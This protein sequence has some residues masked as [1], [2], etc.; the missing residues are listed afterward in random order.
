MSPL[1]SIIVPVYN[2]ENYLRACLDSLINQSLQDVEF[3]CIDDGSSDESPNILDEY[4]A[5]DDRFVVIH[6]E[7]GGVSAARNLGLERA[8][9]RYV[10][11]VDSDD[12][13]SLCACERLVSIAEKENAQIVV[14][15]GKTF[16]VTPW[17]DAS[18]A[19]RNIVY[20]DDS[21]QALLEEQ[22]SNPL[23]CNKL[24]ERSLIEEGHCRFDE[25]LIIGE[26][27]AFQF[28]VFPLAKNIAFT[29]ERF[30]FY[31]MRK[32]SALSSR[33]K[34]HRKIA[35]MHFDVAERILR[36]W[37]SKG[38]IELVPN[39]I[40]AWV[41]LFLFREASQI[42]YNDRLSF[43]VSFS[44]LM[45][46]VFP[47]YKS[48]SVDMDDAT[49]NRISFMLCEDRLADAPLISLVVDGGGASDFSESLYRSIELQTMQ[50]YEILLVCPEDGI[51]AERAALLVEHDS[52][53]SLLSNR[54][55]PQEILGRA[56]GTY[57][58]RIHAGE[59]IEVTTFEQ[60]RDL[61][62]SD[63]GDG[64]PDVVSFSDSSKLMGTHDV[65]Y[66]VEPGEEDVRG[67]QRCV[68]PVDFE[69]SPFGAMSF[70]GCNKL[71]R[72]DHFLACVST[73]CKTTGWAGLYFCAVMNARGMIVTT[74]PLLTI[75]K[76]YSD[77]DEGAHAYVSRII[78]D[79]HEI[80]GLCEE[81]D[82]EGVVCSVKMGLA[83]HLIVSMRYLGDS[84]AFRYAYQ[85]FRTLLEGSLASCDDDPS[86]CED[87]IAEAIKCIGEL[88][89]DE[90]RDYQERW[91][92]SHISEENVINLNSVGALAWER[93]ELERAVEGF[94][95]SISFRIGRAV[96]SIPRAI[97]GLVRK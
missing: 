45:D 39:Q 20:K 90:Y 62:E 4:A 46:E 50:N 96:T 33:A 92:F 1:V 37:K 93:N 58:L 83:K 66:D 72:L 11:F 56:R 34:D 31:R 82:D 13:I 42:P 75:K 69:G 54:L 81:I 55:S 36:H 43:A 59:L 87:E 24:Y 38:Y 86:Y 67:L 49:S 63:E 26:D 94:E 53:V 65:S 89:A 79:I 27:N 21:L 71:I 85:E 2:V 3:I 52:R 88:S 78:A 19:N 23:M 17:A 80:V 70:F 16:P 29:S 64:M 40:F 12:R 22:G 76:I 97:I 35:W 84:S 60:L 8:R 25:N 30:Y 44:E 5:S 9:G 47:G 10:L 77:S 14:F 91:V 6:K 15:G 57:V 48:G 28:E 7:N 41:V 32:D 61:I 51:F 18:F 74:K 73:G 68:S 95:K